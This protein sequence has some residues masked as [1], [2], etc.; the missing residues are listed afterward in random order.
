MTP[1]DVHILIPGLPKSANVFIQRTVELTLD[2]RFVRL[3]TP[4]QR[5]IR[6]RLDEF[7]ALERA[8]GGEHL[9]AIDHNL[10]L[11]SD[12]G[13]GKLAILVRD[14]RDAVIS[15]WHHLER[16]DIK[17]QAEEYGARG[18][19]SAAY[20]DLDRQEKLREL[21]TSEY[22]GYQAWI[23]EWLKVIDDP[24]S[25]LSCHVHRFEDFAADKRKSLRAM[26]AFFGHD[27]EP[28]FPSIEGPRDT[29][30]HPATHFR[31]GQV[32][33]YRDEAPPDLV[34]L[35]DKTLDPGLARRMG[36]T[37]QEVPHAR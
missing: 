24:S 22:P 19:I 21:I 6:D 16:S 26:L 18:G 17:A 37:Q 1:G 7:F 13:V 23:S 27:V 3:V 10:S 34:A 4:A 9:R 14:P 31:R 15:W 8:V 32:G 20:H 11:L 36:W 2:C 33:S 28:V 35:L 25:G 29:G 5:L 12:H 30:I